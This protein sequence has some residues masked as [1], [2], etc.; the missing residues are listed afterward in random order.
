VRIGILPEVLQYN[1][2]KT[3]EGYYSY[4]PIEKFRIV[5]QID[6]LERAKSDANHYKHSNRNYLYYHSENKS[7]P[8]WNWEL[9]KKANVKYIVSDNTIENYNVLEL[10]YDNDLKVYKVL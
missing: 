1:G 3:I 9:L 5:K 2:L 7:Q 8:S 10:I 6:T 4:Y